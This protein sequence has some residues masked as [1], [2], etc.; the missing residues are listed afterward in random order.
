V[1][2]FK[3][4]PA[5]IGAGILL[6]ACADNAILPVEPQAALASAAAS[7][8]MQLAP[9]PDQHL[10]I[11]QGNGVPQKFEARVAELGGTVV[12]ADGRVGIGAVAGLTE[13]TAAML[14]KS[15][16][17]A[18]VELDTQMQPI[19]PFEVSSDV[20]NEDLTPMS[21]G[22]LHYARQWNMRAIGADVAWGAGYTGSSAVTVAILDTGVDATHPDLEGRVDASR[23]KS[24]VGPSE[25]FWYNWWGA[26]EWGDLDGHGTHVAATVSSNAVL[27]AGV[28]S[29][30]QI[31]ALKV[32][33]MTASPWS[34]LSQ[35]IIYAADN[36]ADVIN[37]SLGAYFPRAKNGQFIAQFLTRAVTYA[38]RKGVTVVVS[39]GNEAIDLD[40]DGNNYKVFCSAPVV[41]CVGATGP[42]EGSLGG[43]DAFIGGFSDVDAPSWYSN[44]G[45]SSVD[46]AGPGGN[47]TLNA[48]GNLASGGF[49]WAACSSTRFV[50][51]GGFVFTSPC[52]AD[53]LAGM[54][55][56]SMA[57]PHVS[58]LAALLVERYGRNPGRIASAIHQSADKL[59]SS[60][61][62]PYFGK[63]RINVARALGVSDA[64]A[65]SGQQR[66]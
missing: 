2:S 56:T 47:Y 49:I 64:S 37:M 61:N 20:G 24:F 52:R 65:A 57:T 30:V 48:A 32:L 9:V 6:S 12:F 35:A 16:G 40:H 38:N 62:D 1:K 55:G 22:A 14:A 18:G 25:T 4:L 50:I 13:E 28:T 60:G 8:D 39:S 63:G 58:G 5:L 42:F 23:S 46:V 29:N 44:Y 10:V 11:F 41:I 7:S 53:R 59:A 36:D 26:P 3:T 21:A 31:M 51:Q 43:A 54:A 15:A 33:G 45:R 27:S 19:T 34:G 66:R 17:V